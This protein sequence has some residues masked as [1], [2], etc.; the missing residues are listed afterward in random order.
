M[1]SLKILSCLTL[2]ILLC[3]CKTAAVRSQ[4]EPVTEDFAKAWR[5]ARGDFPEAKATAF[6]D[7]DWATV[8]LPHDW[9]I[10]GPFSEA[11]NARTGG[12]PVHGTAWYRKHFTAGPELAGKRVAVLFDGVMNNS[13]V[14]LNGALIGERPFGYIGFE[15]DLTPHL[16]IGQENVLSVRVAPE[17]LASRWYPGAGIYR[18]VH[19]RVDDPVHV[20]LWG[21]CVTTPGITDDNA[22]VRI[23]TTVR[24]DHQQPAEVTI[25]TLVTEASGAVVATNRQQTTVAATAENVID[26][27]LDINKPVRW[28]LEQP[29]LY[30]ALT[31]LY[32]N[33]KLVDE[34]ESRFGVRTIAFSPTEGFQLNGKRVQLRGVCMHHDLGPLGAAVN[35]RAAQRQLEI[36]QRMGVNA[37]RTSHNPPSPE[38]LELCD[39][40]G[41]VV[42]D[43]AFDEWKIP[44]VVNGYNK[45]FDEWHERDLRDMIRRDRN[46][47]SVIMWSIGNEII[48]QRE[49]DGWRVAKML[50]DICHDEDP[51]R[52]TTAGFNN[53]AGAFKN[54]LAYQV[55]I[56][57]LNYKP[58]EYDNT[59]ADNPEMILY[60]SETSSQTSSRGVYHLP[61]V[62]EFARATGQV[63]GYD[64]V[65]G[66]PWAYPPDVEFDV[67]EQ[68]PSLLGEFMWTGFDYLGEPTPYGGRDNSTNGYWN[69]DW[70]SHSS[71]FAPVDLVGLPK[72][73]FYLYQSQ[74]T[75]APMI[76]LLPHWNWTGKE[77]ESIPVFAYTNADAAELFLNGKSL[78]KK[79]KGVDLTYIP[80]EF[81]GFPRGSYASR[82]RLSWEVP[83]RAGALKVVAY[84]NG[85]IVAEDEVHTAGPPAAIRLEADRSELSATGDDLSFVTVSIVDAAGNLCPR[86][87]SRIDFS[88]TGEG[89]LEAV[90]NGDATS[91]EGFQQ[92]HVQAFSG[93]CVAI[94]R[95]GELPGGITLTARAKGLQPATLELRVVPPGQ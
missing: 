52:P 88:V 85:A 11:H 2:V 95:G 68:N 76:H 25:E 23:A 48:E 71:Y 86:E 30:T 62:P 21:T 6:D 43:E 38:V 14:Y 78:G 4:A 39:R 35:R 58:Y 44:K 1:K 34:Y 74:W 93:R 63:S 33:G 7:G 64:V 72:D 91:L 3:A 81:R 50:N 79:V 27:S 9:A 57:G 13:S 75:D 69:D 90:G 94:V 67:Q 8:R 65:V 28:R 54:K 5:F 47:P 19:L 80:A 24:N 49:K 77:G 26:V 42:I 83:Y 56:V 70:P 29:H 31:R 84:R 87:G 32:H 36:M 55:D 66:P 37:I 17:D 10:A 22:A 60:G 51:S 20:P 82:Y 89:S 16:R 12:L 18:N 46:H 41:I 73:R 53:Y 61:I 92:K 15:V 45:Y 59:I 40:M